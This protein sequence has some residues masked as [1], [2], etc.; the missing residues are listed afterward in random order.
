[1]SSRRVIAGATLAAPRS[2]AA[3]AG[4]V[5][6]PAPTLVTTGG[7]GSLDRYSR[8]LG[9]TLPVPTLEAGLEGRAGR[10]F[11]VPLVSRASATSAATDVA[12][13]RR[14]R[15]ARRPLH[16]PNQHLARHGRFLARPY[17]VTVHDVIR[18][19]DAGAEGARRIH[20]PN[21]RDRLLLALDRDGIRRAA[22]IIA[23]SEATRRDVVDH[24]GVAPERVAVVHNGVDH[25]TFRPLCRRL[26]DAPYVLF[27]G[28]EHPRKNLGGVLRALRRLASDRRHADLRLVKVGDP[29]GGEAPFRRRTL[30]AL[31]ELGLDRR[32]VFTGRVPD[33]ELA[34]WYAGAL[35]LVL[36]SHHEGFG[37]PALEAMACGCPVVVSDRGA[38]AE[39]VGDAGLLVDPASDAELTEALDAL[40]AGG[41]RD[42][43]VA[44]GLC[45]ARRFSWGRAAA[46]TL[47]AYRRFLPGGAR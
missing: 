33:E 36:P 42:E 47:A 30:A 16:L 31:A 14:L 20:R 6:Q 18:H 21:R 39:V 27:V 2:R 23:V 26:L 17:V 41:P 5:A 24:L 8:W 28:S 37:L 11:G 32:V 10:R 38:L 7:G 15:R 29:G 43:L 13:V 45:R 35:C 4:A 3:P 9:A 40:L 46:E 1:M 19:L 25:A 22:G 34:A 44:R 12:L